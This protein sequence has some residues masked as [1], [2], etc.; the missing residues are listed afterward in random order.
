MTA[1]SKTSFKK[2]KLSSHLFI[3]KQLCILLHCALTWFL[4]IQMYQNVINQGGHPI[5]LVFMVTTL[6]ETR[7]LLS[8]LS[9][10]CG[11]HIGLTAVDREGLCFIKQ[12][13]SGGGPTW[14]PPPPPPP[15]PPHTPPP[16]P[17]HTP[18]PA[19]RWNPSVGGTLEHVKSCVVQS[20]GI[21]LR[22]SSGGGGAQ[23]ANSRDPGSIPRRDA[24][25]GVFLG[26]CYTYSKTTWQD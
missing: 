14:P 17:P 16:P 25:F 1:P 23:E 5:A 4:Q 24:T 21:V 26:S 6:W 9:F 15:T 13:S 22:W 11:T 20:R 12:K 10:I 19:L 7:H 2:Y 18:P 3:S 8:L